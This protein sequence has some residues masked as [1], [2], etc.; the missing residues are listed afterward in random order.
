MSRQMH[1]HPLSVQPPTAGEQS[2]PPT[3]IVVVFDLIMMWS[4][5]LIWSSMFLLGVAVV[6]A[7]VHIIPARSQWTLHLQHFLFLFIWIDSSC[8]EVVVFCKQC[9]QRNPPLSDLT[10]TLKCTYFLSMCVWY[11]RRHVRI[12]Q[13]KPF[14]LCVFV[15]LG[16]VCVGSHGSSRSHGESRVTA[17]SWTQS[18]WFRCWPLSTTPCM[19]LSH[20]T[21]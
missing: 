21:I 4:L 9:D 15:S 8:M 14:S 5:C 11:V 16:C 3:G 2:P 6:P 13:W 10:F 1:T 18:S 20:N 7:V 17:C 19:Y 12:D